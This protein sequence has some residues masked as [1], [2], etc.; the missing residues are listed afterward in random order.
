MVLRQAAQLLDH[1]SGDEAEVARIGRQLDVRE[2][3]EQS[4]ERGIAQPQPPGF[5]PSDARRIHDVV[6]LRHQLDERRNRLRAI[7]QVAVHDDGRITSHD[8][9]TP[10]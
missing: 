3:R 6:A 4:I 5:L 7:L 10:P 8:G 2:V 1:A 9:S